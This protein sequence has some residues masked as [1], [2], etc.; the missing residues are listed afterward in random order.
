MVVQIPAGF[1]K[2][3]NSNFSDVLDAKKKSLLEIAIRSRSFIIFIC[4]LVSRAINFSNICLLFVRITAHRVYFTQKP[5]LLKKLTLFHCL[6]GKRKA[7]APN[8]AQNTE[9]PPFLSA[10]YLVS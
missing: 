5:N 3:S 7:S 10:S 9:N 6:C 4:T 8:K 1:Q 2:A